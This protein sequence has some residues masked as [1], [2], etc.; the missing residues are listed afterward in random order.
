MDIPKKYAIEQEEQKWRDFWQQEQLYKFISNKKKPF[1]IDTPPPTLSGRM[2]IG[3]ASSYTQQD[4]IA[5]YKRMAGFNVCYPFGTDDNGLPTERLVEKTKKVRSTAME[6][7][8][9][10]DLCNATIKEI[11][12]EFVN[13]WI[14]IGMSCDF[15]GSYSTI[16]PHCI[17]T[18]QAAFIDLFEKGLV[19][20]E[21]APVSWCPTCQTAIA[22]AEFESVDKQSHFN[23]IVF[24]VGGK[25]LII[26]TTRPELLPSCVAVL[27]HPEDKRYTDIIGKHATTPLFNQEVPIL[28][29]IRADPEKGSGAVMC[30]T[31]GDKT[32][33]EWWKDHKLPLKISITKH[34]KMNDLAGPYKDLKILD[35]RKK[36]LDDLKEKKLLIRQQDITHPVN[37]HERC[38]TDVEI[39]KTKQWFVKVL[40][41]KQELIDAADR[42]NWYPQF[43]KARYI[44]WVENLNWNWCI[45]RQRHFGVPFPVWYDKEGKVIVAKKEQLPV[46]PL[47]DQPQGYTQTMT[48]EADVMDTWATSSVTP[49]IITNW[50]DK[51][52][53]DLNNQHYP[54]NLR[55]QAHDI[56]RT[57]AFYTIVKGLYINNDVPWHD[58][59][60]SGHVLDPTGG[61]LS[62]SK[63]ASTPDAVLTQ[64]GAD[65]L[66]FWT[67]GSKLGDDVSF[68][69]K[70]LQTGKRTV[71]KLWNASSFVAM[72]LSDFDKSINPILEPID[73]WLLSKCN[74]AI[75]EATKAF[76]R[77]DYAKAR[78][79][80]DNFFWRVIC[81]NY[82]EI[83]KE[84]LYKPEVHGEQS[85]QAAQYALAQVMQATLKMFA[86]FLPFITESCYQYFFKAE[87]K[88][89]HISSWPTQI[90]NVETT[91]D[92]K[93]EQLL[94]V[95]AAI[96]SA[97]SG[98]G[99]ALNAE[100]K[101][102]TITYND[103]ISMFTDDIKRVAKADNVM[104]KT[105]DLNIAYEK[106]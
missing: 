11:K 66:R 92:A 43:M 96:R 101:T 100:L 86:P 49:Q 77:Y 39:L 67:G 69:E 76:D 58:I 89:I 1:I 64:F 57:W 27:V 74:I 65:A 55:T 83:V 8:A 93:G 73:H 84:R 105:G 106:K 56:I 24:T 3:H 7:Q 95:V 22:Q 4:F 99:I 75:A 52:G 98:Q 72:H 16:D 85:R 10:I 12:P 31:F 34:G 6:R 60:I 2:H 42:I 14:R 97:K 59:V 88:S 71:N 32:D 44:H 20:Q 47:K 37:T 62:K 5:R 35:A 33:I 21:E 53:Y 9:F 94:E 91:Y 41:K 28:A 23:D 13:D 54:T 104:L 46:D 90:P 87:E 38:G 51:G 17:A 45:S 63:G 70:D 102:L 15:D 19:Y 82:L 103:D 36:I 18:S 40:D 29:D 81:D 68:Q 25:E 78:H 79:V 61:K 26:A 30:C 80:T 50:F 48:P